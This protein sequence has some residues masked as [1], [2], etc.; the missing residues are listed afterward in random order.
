MWYFR[1]WLDDYCLISFPLIPSHWIYFVVW[2]LATMY[3]NC[4]RERKEKNF[5]KSKEYVE[6]NNISKKSTQYLT[7]F[8]NSLYIRNNII[9][10]FLILKIYVWTFLLILYNWEW[11]IVD[12]QYLKLNRAVPQDHW[13]PSNSHK[14]VQ[15]RS[16]RLTQ[17]WPCDRKNST[18]YDWSKV[19]IKCFQ[20]LLRTPRYQNELLAF[21]Q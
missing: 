4:R 16:W 11:L 8:D 18:Y 1:F 6:M 13:A 7:W 15:P 10:I 3:R 12:P 2:S 5:K 17:R 21:Y 19:T 9:N 20:L 14:W